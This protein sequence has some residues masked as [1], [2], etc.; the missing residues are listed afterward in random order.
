M[1]IFFKR[2]VL[3]AATIAAF[4]TPFIAASTAS[5]HT[6]A[7]G[8]SKGANAGSVNLFMGSYHFDN[9]GDGPNFEGSAHLT[10][11]SGYDTYFPFTTAYETGTLPGIL[12]F[13]NVQF[14]T[15]YSL[16]SIHSWEGV[17]VNGLTAAGT[18]NFAYSNAA[19]GSAHWSPF[20]T[21]TSFALTEA[22]LAGGGASL[23]ADVPEPAS[24]ALIGLGLAGLGLRRRK[25]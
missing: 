8:W 17:T 18:Y 19:F 1:K 21:T 14:F 15:G 23:S 11:P 3:T 24:L 10:G 4:L 16:A 25:S 12:P 20:S 6:V 13:A 9:V 22:D 2:T 7:I 5:A